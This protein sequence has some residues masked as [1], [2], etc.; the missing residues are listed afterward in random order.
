[1]KTIKQNLD[2]LVSKL[3]T[4]NCN[5]LSTN[6]RR[7]KSPDLSGQLHIAKNIVPHLKNAH[8]LT[9]SSNCEAK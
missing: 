3:F 2:N 4:A 6:L 8:R 9:D 7:R 1:M 5:K